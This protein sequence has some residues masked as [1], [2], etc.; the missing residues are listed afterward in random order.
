MLCRQRLAEIHYTTI[1]VLFLFRNPAVG[2]L[3]K[4]LIRQRYQRFYLLQTKF[5]QCFFYFCVARFKSFH[6]DH[7]FGIIDVVKIR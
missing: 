3:R 6:I 5:N 4:A 2:R 1:I 7:F